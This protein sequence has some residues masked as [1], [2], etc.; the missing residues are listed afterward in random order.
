MLLIFAI[1]V[2]LIEH[3]YGLEILKPLA[4]SA[5]LFFIAFNFKPL[6][7]FGKHGDISY[8]IYIFHFPII[9]LFVNYHIF[10]KYNPWVSAGL[11][12]M[13]VIVLAFLSWNLLEKRFLSRRTVF[14]SFLST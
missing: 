5:M 14:K 7:N 12:I 11:I 9:Q 6:N 2:F 10:E 1:P 4:L 8:G 13:L 3:Y